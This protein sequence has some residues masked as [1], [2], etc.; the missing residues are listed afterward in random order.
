VSTE[1]RNDIFTKSVFHVWR[2]QP[3]CAEKKAKQ[4]SASSISSSNTPEN[5][6]RL[7]KH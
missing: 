3:L 1:E 7:L 2:R 4:V 5:I 6:T